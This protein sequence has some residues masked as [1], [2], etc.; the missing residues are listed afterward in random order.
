MDEETPEQREA[1]QE[2][3]RLPHQES[4]AVVPSDE[5]AQQERIRRSCARRGHALHNHEDLDTSMVTGPNVVDGRHRL[6]PTT[7]CDHCN[8]WKWPAETKKP[9]C[10]EGGVKLPSLPPAPTRLLQLYKDPEFRK[11]IRAYNQVFAFTFTPIGASCN[12]RSNF[13]L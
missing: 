8:A 3:D 11:H 12:N 2:R 4:R 1:R 6:P 13:S 9:C 5:R 10:L 7:V